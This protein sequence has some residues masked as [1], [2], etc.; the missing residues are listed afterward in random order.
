VIHLVLFVEAERVPCGVSVDPP[1]LAGLVVGLDRTEGED[2]FLGR[3]EVLDREVQVYLLRTA[4]VGPRRRDELQVLLKADPDADAGVQ[5]DPFPL[6]V[7]DL[8]GQLAVEHGELMRIRTIQDHSG[9]P[10]QG[11]H[12]R[13]FCRHIGER[14]RAIPSRRGALPVGSAS[15]NW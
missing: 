2:E 12:G 14:A 6:V 10:C 4:R 15:P 5:G 8:A 13:E 9:Q 1:G 7:L 3:V 11:S